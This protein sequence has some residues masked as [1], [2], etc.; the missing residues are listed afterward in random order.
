MG[1]VSNM[2]TIT[3]RIPEGNFRRI[4]K[5]RKEFGWTWERYFQY[6]FNFHMAEEKA[7]KEMDRYYD[8]KQKEVKA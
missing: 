4:N 1:V 3:I 8:K 2:K 6:L 7:Y 5:Y